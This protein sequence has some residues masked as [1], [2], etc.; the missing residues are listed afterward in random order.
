MMRAMASFC[1]Q[2][3]AASVGNEPGAA[4]KVVSHGDFSQVAAWAAVRILGNGLRFLGESAKKELPSKVSSR[5][6]P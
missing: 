1:N 4:A 3:Y 5:V 6:S 2:W